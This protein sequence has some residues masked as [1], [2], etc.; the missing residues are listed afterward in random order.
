[1]D[2]QIEEVNSWIDLLTSQNN[3]SFMISG[4]RNFWPLLNQYPDYKEQLSLLTENDDANQSVL[5]SFKDNNGYQ[6]IK[7]FLEANPDPKSYY[8]LCAF[9]AKR[10]SEMTFTNQ[11]YANFLGP[12]SAT[13]KSYEN[14]KARLYFINTYILPLSKYLERGHVLKEQRVALLKRYRTL[15]T[16][17]D[18]EDVQGRGE[19]YLTSTHLPHFLFSEG[20]DHVFSETIVPSG[21]IDTFVESADMIVEA[22]IYNGKNLS[23]QSECISQA[24]GRLND[25]DYDCAYVVIYNQS[26]KVLDIGEADDSTL[27][28]PYWTINGKRIY[29]LVIDT[30]SPFKDEKEWRKQ[31]K[32]DSFDK[33][34]YLEEIKK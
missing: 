24:L 12:L 17:Y 7:D 20:I 10:C 22:K 11:M 32:V 1:M 16:W 23:E 26:D 25:L 31:A 2:Y 18:R 33:S 13:D 14:E 19:L 5:L 34:Y 3:G 8:S 6:P 30:Y 29:I 4:L 27:G 15:C 21:R 9:V 28:V